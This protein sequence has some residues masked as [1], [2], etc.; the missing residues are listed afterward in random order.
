VSYKDP[1]GKFLSPISTKKTTEKEA[2]KVAFD[3][4]RDGIPKKNALLKVQDLALKDVVQKLKTEAEAETLLAELQRS[5]WIKQFI[6]N[7]TPQA[8]DFIS[9][10]KT[11]WDWDTSPYIREKLRKSHG[12][13]KRHCLIQGQAITLHWE[14][15]FKG[16]CLGDI[17]AIDIDAF[18][19][20]MGDKD[21]SASRKNVIIKAGTKPLRWAFSKGKI[22]KDPTRGHIMFSGDEAER[23]IVTPAVAAALFRA[24]WKN[25]RAKHANMIAAVTGMRSGEILALRLQD[26]GADCLYVRG[27][28]NSTDKRK[29][30]KNNKTRTVELPFPGLIRELF[31]QAQRN[32]WGV[33]PDSF[34]FWSEAKKG[35]PMSSQIFVTGL[36]DALRQIGFAE[37][38][39]QKYVFHGWRHFFTAYMIR[40]LDKKLLKSQT[41]HLTDEM[42]SHYG[43]HETEGDR[44]LIQKHERE[45]FAG[46]LPD[47]SDKIEYAIVM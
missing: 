16:R 26:L 35:I 13:H 24:D 44:E 11:F 36:R 46:L 8:E 12:I 9:F 37:D 43:N 6:L 4:M 38:E 17:T 19:D 33:S 15:F 31:E 18:I 34:V 47:P 42:L 28:W 29:G 39:A 32:P 23:N 22:D 14:P 5:G 45:A 3:W 21:L 25:D 40:R 10:L 20:H 7:D 27:S 30:T 2:M 41:G 1:S